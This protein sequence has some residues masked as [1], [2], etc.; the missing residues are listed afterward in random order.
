MWGATGRPLL[1]AAAF[2]AWRADMAARAR[3]GLLLLLGRAAA[4]GAAAAAGTCRLSGD[5]MIE[6]LQ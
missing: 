6:S 5:N 1:H 2:D 3:A 4:D